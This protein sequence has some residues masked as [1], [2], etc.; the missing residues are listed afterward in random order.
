MRARVESEPPATSGLAPLALPNV[1]IAGVAN[2]PDDRYGGHRLPGDHPAWMRDSLSVSQRART[3]FE[4]LKPVVLTVIA[5]WEHRLR[6][7]VVGSTRLSVDASGSYRR[8]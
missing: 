3:L 5:A 1:A 8:E 6:S 7:I 4:R 2:D